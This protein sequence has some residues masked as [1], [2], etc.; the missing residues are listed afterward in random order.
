MADFFVNQ[1]TKNVLKQHE[2]QE[3]IA[4][5]EEEK[6][7]GIRTTPTVV[8]RKKNRNEPLFFPSKG[9]MSTDAIYD[10]QDDMREIMNSG[11]PAQVVVQGQYFQYIPKKG[12]V[13]VKFN[14]TGPNAGK[15]TWTRREGKLRYFTKIEDVLAQMGV[16]YQSK[17]DILPATS[18]KSKY[19]IGQIYDAKG[20]KYKW[21]GQNMIKQ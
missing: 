20:I 3:E 2:A 12:W 7:K 16:Q 10:I 21:D 15:Y 5:N 1:I 19:V 6:R 14:E 17:G 9:S 18:G 8:K 11:K 13:K 4:K